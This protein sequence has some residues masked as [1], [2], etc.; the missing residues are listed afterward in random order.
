[1]QSHYLE[2]SPHEDGKRWIAEITGPD[3]AFGLKREF[4]PEITPGVYQIFDGYYQI[5]G[6]FPGITPFQKEYVIVQDG[7]MTRRVSYQVIRQNIPAIVAYTPQRKERL[8]YQIKEQFKEIYEAAPYY[9]VQEELLQQE[10][11]LGMVD[12]S[13]AL[14]QGLTTILKQKDQMIAYYQKAHEAGYDA[15]G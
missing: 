8:I 15:W 13:E 12:T 5:H 7:Q 4:Q 6:I 1:M 10:E 14:L 3:E 9:F 2:L 11:S